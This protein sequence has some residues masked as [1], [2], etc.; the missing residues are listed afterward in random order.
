MGQVTV[1]PRGGGGGWTQGGGWTRGGGKVRAIP[2][3]EGP[4]MRAIAASP[5]VHMHCRSVFGGDMS[6]TPTV[7]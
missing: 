3:G 2:W 4:A 1:P 6:G 5:V 7:K